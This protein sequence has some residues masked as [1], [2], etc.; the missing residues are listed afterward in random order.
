MK[1]AHFIIADTKETMDFR[2]RPRVAVMALILLLGCMS[3]GYTAFAQTPSQGPYLKVLG[4]AQD[5]GLPHAACNCE[6]C[7][8]ARQKPG[9]RRHVASLALVLPNTE[10]VYLFD[11]TPDLR[12]QLALLAHFGPDA[13]RQVDRDPVAGVFLTHAHIGHYLGLAF[14][15]Y[16]AIHTQGLPVIATPQMAKFLRS[17]GPWSQLVTM[18]N[19]VLEEL[20]PGE[21][22]QV[23]E[24]IVVQAVRAPHRDEYADTL[25]FLIRGQQK[26]VFYLPDTDSWTAWPTPVTDLLGQVDVALLDGT[27]FAA[28]ELP[29]RRVEEIGHPLIRDSMNLLQDLVD[30]HSLEVYFTHLNH[31]NSALDADG[32]TRQLIE[33]RGFHVLEQGQEISL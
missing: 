31:S 10:Q 9:Y 27:F 20:T 13:E 21:H 19:I 16:E 25:G 32:E 26:T 17:N 28:D 23:G 3:G 18:Q 11:A 14:F 1:E 30:H 33:K 29:G 5:G 24:Q 6:R 22:R 8:R 7:E 4:I 12:E 2:V 15:G